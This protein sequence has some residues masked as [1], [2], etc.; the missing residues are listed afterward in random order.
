MKHFAK[1]CL[2]L[3]FTAVFMYPCTSAIITGRASESGRPILWKHR[4][5]GA[6]ENKVVH[7]KGEKYA[8][9]GIYNVSDTLNREMWMGTNETGFSI[10][11][12]ASY[13][14][15][16]GLTWDKE[17]D[18]EGLFMKKALGLCA[19]VEEFEAFL[20]SQ[21][22][23]WGIETNIGVIDAQ[24]GAAF[25][26]TGYHNFVKYDVNDPAVAPSGYLIRTNF[27]FA[28][29]PHDGQGY[30]RYTETSDLFQK[31]MLKGKLSVEFLLK[32]ATRNM[33]HG[34]LKREIWDDYLPEDF[35]DEYMV[36]LQDYVVRYWSASVLVVEGIK[37][38]EDRGATTLWT[39]LGF[40]LTTLVTPVW[41]G[42][43]DLLPSVLVSDNGKN[44]PI[45]DWSLTLKKRCFPYSK[46]NSHAYI[47]SAPLKNKQQ[48]GYV[49]KLVPM[50]DHIISQTK[51]LQE[52]FYKSGVSSKDVKRFNKWLD[53]YVR[54]AYETYFDQMGIK[55]P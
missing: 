23:L 11:N 36:S 34:L 12:T 1:I 29:E 44:P 17:K 14:I 52:Q 3:V 5:T 20:K 42:S 33:H 31:E 26:E 16:E 30:I 32:K 28:G 18:Q 54:S 40:P 43:G 37:K 55:Y 19:T 25:Y 48:T 53:D 4:D 2:I 35:N 45:V 21:S 51:T 38:G 49:Q 7:L 9:T 47:N 22:G 6:L 8:F 41:I 10:M 50:E 46:G 15:T 39:L 27:S 13:N 24:G